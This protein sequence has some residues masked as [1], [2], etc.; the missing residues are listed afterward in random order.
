M[1]QKGYW[2]AIVSSILLTVPFAWGKTKPLTQ[3]NVINHSVF[4]VMLKTDTISEKITDC[5]MKT[6]CQPRGCT[7]SPRLFQLST[8]QFVLP[9]CNTPTAAFNVYLYDYVINIDQTQNP[10]PPPILCNSAPLQP[11]TNYN[12]TVFANVGDVRPQCFVS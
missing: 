5:S 9:Y 4:S 1:S 10:P 11:K 2:F 6:K 7:I 8:A 12:V 3:F